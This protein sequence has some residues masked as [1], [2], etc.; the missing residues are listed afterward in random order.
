MTDAQF[1]AVCAGGVLFLGALL[2][3]V[4]RGSDE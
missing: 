1:F 2:Y 3:I 4:T